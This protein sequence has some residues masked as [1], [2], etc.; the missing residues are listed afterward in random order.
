[1]RAHDYDLAMEV[2]EPTFTFMRSQTDFA[3]L[4]IKELGDYLIYREKD[5]GKA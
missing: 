4:T 1:M 2:L 3:R 5:V